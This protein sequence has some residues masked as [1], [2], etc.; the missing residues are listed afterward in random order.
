LNPHFVEFT[1]E[2]E[3]IR[4]YYARSDWQAFDAIAQKLD[5]YCT[6]FITGGSK[7][8]VYHFTAPLE[9]FLEI[10]NYCKTIKQEKAC[11]LLLN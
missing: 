11:T 3:K 1:I 7:G 8:T 5:G 9:L 4:E 10:E 6:H 2:A